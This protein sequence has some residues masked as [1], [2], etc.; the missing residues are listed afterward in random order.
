[1]KNLK[2]LI[3]FFVFLFVS[4]HVLNAQED[5]FFTPGVKVGG[6]VSNL[7]GF[8]N[9]EYNNNG[10]SANVGVT[11]GLTADFALTK[12]WTILTGFEY[13][14]KGMGIKRKY[15]NNAPTSKLPTYKT[16]YFQIPLRIG[17]KVKTGD[18]SNIIFYAGPYFAYGFSG[19][20]KW[21]QQ[22]NDLPHSANIFKDDLFKRFDWGLGAGLNVNSK[23]FALNLGCDYGLSDLTRSNFAY[24]DMKELDTS[25]LSIHSLCIYL[26]VGYK[27]RM[28]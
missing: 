26:T 19:D 6:N 16:Q 5:R 7:L 11:A 22:L 27:W 28:R 23:N 12:R 15:V 9:K 24:P 1:M 20:V 13:V 10:T 25:D 17:Y 8:D 14:A 18:F 4:A 21:T 2:C 3:L